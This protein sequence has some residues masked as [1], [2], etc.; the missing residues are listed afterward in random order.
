MEFRRLLIR[1]HSVP[2]PST[3]TPIGY[4]STVTPATVRSEATLIIAS[5]CDRRSRCD[6]PPTFHP[7]PPARGSPPSRRRNHESSTLLRPP[8]HQDRGHPRA[9]SAPGH[10]RDRCRMVRNLR[11]R[12]ARVS[13]GADLRPTR[14]D[15]KSTRLNSSH[16]ATSYA[17]FCLKK[18]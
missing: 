1:S 14:R 13:L 16:V 15:R 3:Y 6:R 2:Y 5:Y 4:V 18:K 12:P 11:H 8:G 9:R 17:V 10:S 7:D